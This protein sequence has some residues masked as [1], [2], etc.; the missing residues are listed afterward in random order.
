MHRAEWEQRW[1]AK[2]L[3][4]LLAFNLQAQMQL[5]RALVPDMLARGSGHFVNIASDPPGNM[6]IDE[7]AVQR[8]EGDYGVPSVRRSCPFRENIACSPTSAPSTRAL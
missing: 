2:D 8:A 6:V 4:G 7:L 5:A 3:H 1:L